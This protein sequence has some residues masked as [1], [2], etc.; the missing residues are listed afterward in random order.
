MIRKY[1]VISEIPKPSVT[2][3]DRR[4][5]DD[6]YTEI[7]ADSKMHIQ[8]GDIASAQ[9]WGIANTFLYADGRMKIDLWTGIEM[10]PEDK[11]DIENLARI[12]FR[13]VISEEYIEEHKRLFAKH[14]HIYFV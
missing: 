14:S 13:K 5:Y 3:H 12:A 11:K 6:E 4:K 2:L 8:R 9:F 10:D 7:P 1:E